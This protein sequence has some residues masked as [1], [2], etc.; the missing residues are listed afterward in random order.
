MKRSWWILALALIA[1][2]VVGVVGL[3][4]EEGE[5][6]ALMVSPQRGD[7]EVAVTVTGELRAKNSV[8]IYGPRRAQQAGIFEIKISQLIPEGTV[9]QAGE[10]VAELDRSE[11]TTKLQ[12]A[13][14]EVQK[15]QSQFTQA[16]LDSALALSKARDNLVDLRYAMEEARIKRDQSVYEPPSVR[17]QADIDYEK[18]A[19]TL[20]RSTANYETE[21]QQATAKMAEAEA[22]LR[23]AQNGLTGL[24]TILNEFTVL[25]P[26]NGMVIYRRDWRGERLTE[27]GSIRAWDPVVAE[28]P[29]LSLMESVAYV[30]EVDIQKVQPGQTVEMTLDAMPD[31][32]LTGVVSDVANI[33]EQRPNSDAK[34]FEV[35]LLV[36]EADSTLRPGMSTGNTILVA[37]AADVM[38]VPLETI[39][40][41]DS[42]TY[43]FV[44]RGRLLRQEVRLGFLNE[45][46]AIV[47]AGLS[48]DDDIYLS[49]PPDTQGVRLERLPSRDAG[50]LASP[51][52][53]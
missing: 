49:L 7:F 3:G 41:T 1:V 6:A 21:V 42:L 17:R 29:D 16:Q 10:F 25:A 5:A 52:D 11:L 19:R 30:N 51:G 20:D 24:L 12:E 27:G 23:Q 44:R 31:T 14:I 13:E 9:V 46:E 22:T 47:E 53:D 43:V 8:K 4:A 18:A 48:L 32:R 37:Q 26:E 2:L 45:N 15:A 38:S 28:L 40:T 35:R 50:V 39:H 33:G 36:N 34:V